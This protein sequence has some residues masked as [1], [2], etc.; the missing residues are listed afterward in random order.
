MADEQ[1]TTPLPAPDQDLPASTEEQ[2]KQDGQDEQAER[3]KPMEQPLQPAPPSRPAPMSCAPRR[4][5]VAVA[6]SAVAWA[7]GRW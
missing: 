4:E 3:Q 7:P 5:L 1:H 6:P 2:R